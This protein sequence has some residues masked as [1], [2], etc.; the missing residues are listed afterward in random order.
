MSEVT[1]RDREWMAEALALARRGHDLAARVQTFWESGDGERPRLVDKN[2]YRN[3]CRVVP[4]GVPVHVGRQEQL[5]AVLDQ[6]PWARP[7]L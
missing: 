5:A 4:E 1:P 7:A 3:F 6:A 2:A